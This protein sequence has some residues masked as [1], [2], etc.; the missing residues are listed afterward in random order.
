MRAAT[1]AAALP[2][3]SETAVAHSRRLQA[4]IAEEITAAGGALRFDRYMELALYAPGLGYYVGGAS[5]FGAGGD[6]V[7]APEMTPM[8]G[9]TLARFVATA[10]ASLPEF[11]VLEVGAGS[12]ALAAALLPE[13]AALGRL[14]RHYRILDTS[15]DLRARQQQLVAP[16]AESAGVRLVFENSL[17]GEP[18]IG[19]VIANE[20]LDAIPVRRF[21]V[22]AEGPRELLV[23]DRG[24]RFDW[25][26]ADRLEQALADELQRVQGRVSWSWPLGYQSEL[27]PARR[28]WLASLAERLAHGV[29]LLIDYGYTAAEFYHPHRGDGTLACHYRHHRLDDP[30]LWPGLVDIGAH[31]D[32]SDLAHAASTCGLRVAGFTTQAHFLLG[33]G[34]L[35]LCAAL[36]PG[37]VDYVRAAGAVQRLTLPQEMGETVR[38]MALEAGDGG[39]ALPGFATA[40]LRGRL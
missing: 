21:R 34:L 25:V 33:N 11:D 36:D 30:F 2:A 28:G 37:S 24:D 29:A 19:V 8:F 13:L 12:G 23:G 16:L 22:T 6:F 4:L 15:P 10:S 18:L 32:F 17:A 27:G 40:D 31:V 14:P 20:L 39:A 7:T 38:V 3:P 9:R 26:V 35:D 1:G 5:K